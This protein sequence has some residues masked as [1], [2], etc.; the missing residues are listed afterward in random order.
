MTK[1]NDI[2]VPEGHLEALQEKLLQIPQAQQAPQGIRRVAPYLAYAASLAALVVMGNLILRRTAVQEE[3]STWDYYSY[4]AQSLDPD[5]LVELTEAEDL[6]NED[7][8]NFL[9]ADNLSVEQLNA[10][11]YE[12]DY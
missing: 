1:R 8:V 3:D 4:L 9:L 5:G 11:N 12:E 7:I 2:S 6:T 10:L